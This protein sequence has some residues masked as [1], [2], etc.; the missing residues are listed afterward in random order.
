MKKLIFSLASILI[1]S[2]IFAITPQEANKISGVYELV[3]VIY[4]QRDACAQDIKITSKLNEAKDK[5]LTV[6]INTLTGGY[7][8]YYNF[9]STVFSSAEVQN[10]PT[11]LLKTTYHKGQ[12]MNFSEIEKDTLSIRKRRNNK[13]SPYITIENKQYPEWLI[14]RGVAYLGSIFVDDLKDEYIHTKCKYKK[15]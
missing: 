14:V 7:V 1:S 15:I 4:G 2:N 3:N 13:I 5:L 12:D 10:R 8:S 6:K 11:S 9:D